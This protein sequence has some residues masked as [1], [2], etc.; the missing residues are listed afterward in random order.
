MNKEF[1]QKVLGAKRESKHIE[2]KESIDPSSKQ[3]WCEIIKDLIA[4]AN[5]GGGAILFGVNNKG[6]P[7]GINLSSI[8]T[9]DPARIADN[10]HNYTETHFADFEIHEVEK[11]G[12]QL[13][14]WI[15]GNSSFPM[16]FVT[17][18]DLSHSGG[19]TT[20]CLREGNNILSSWSQ[21]RTRNIPRHR[22]FIGA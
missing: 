6:V 3:D 13:I 2:F 21:K 7:T 16:V 17:P 4:I 9:L 8:K 1:F 14:L 22:L 19:Q 15:I 10:I 11:L 5:S 20:N 18:G 12:H